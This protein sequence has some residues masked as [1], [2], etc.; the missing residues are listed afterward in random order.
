[1][2]PFP[3]V[4]LIF[5][6]CITVIIILA[7]LKLFVFWF[8][9]LTSVMATTDTQLPSKYDKILWVTLFLVVPIIA[10]FLYTASVEKYNQKKP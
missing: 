10:P 6:L 1:M 2:Q 3:A 4:T 9:S 8:R 5:T 7:A